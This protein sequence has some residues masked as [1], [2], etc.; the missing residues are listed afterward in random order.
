MALCI[1]FV[2]EIMSV[3]TSVAARERPLQLGVSLPMSGV[4]AMIPRLLNFLYG[5]DPVE[6][7]CAYGLDESV[8]RLRAA[9]KKSSFSVLAEPAVVGTV[10]Q[11]KVKLQRVIPMVRNSF[12]PFF[13]GQ[14]VV[15]GH[16]VFLVGRFTLPGLVKI[17]MSCWFGFLGIFAIVAVA[18]TSFGTAPASQT[19]ALVIG[20]IAMG[21]FGVGLVAFGKWLARNDTAWL[22]EVVQG[23]IG[24][25]SVPGVANPAGPRVP[26]AA[27]G[28]RATVVIVTAGVLAAMGAMNLAVSIAGS[29]LPLYSSGVL[30]YAV[31]GQGI[32]LLAIAL[33]IYLRLRVAWQAGFVLI[34][35]AWVFS[36]ANVFL[37]ND[38]MAPPL[39]VRI[40]FAGIGLLIAI[41]WGRWW[42]AQRIHFVSA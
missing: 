21:A 22:K 19:F 11:S 29:S 27:F 41:V 9:T 18:Q 39:G 12:K 15:R 23:A 31:A 35:G 5:S 38:K 17:F 42:N 40:A 7:E 4:A 28:G 34:A 24:N 36:V 1:Y 10:T 20:P 25:D 3:R 13:I 8:E 37:M 6:W 32:L 16:R 14:F 30:R 33:G 2:G 26:G